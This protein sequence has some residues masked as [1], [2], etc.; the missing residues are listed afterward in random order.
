[1]SREQEGRNDARAAGGGQGEPADQEART[2]SDGTGDSPCPPTRAV[3]DAATTDRWLRVRQEETNSAIRRDEAATDNAIRRLEAESRARIQE[4][5]A[6]SREQRLKMHVI[7][8]WALI[9][10][11]AS[12]MLIGVPVGAL[13]VSGRL[14]RVPHAIPLSAVGGLVLTLGAAGIRLWMRRRVGRSGS[15]PPR[16]DGSTTVR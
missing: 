5:A 16:T 13:A 10:V 4:E 6:H 7:G 3:Q 2:S 14:L 8:S 9:L 15:G 11:V 12:V 1:M